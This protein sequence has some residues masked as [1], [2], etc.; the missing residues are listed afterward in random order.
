LRLVQTAAGKP[1]NPS[2]LGRPPRWR[3]SAR[4]QASMSPVDTPG[5]MR[6]VTAA[7]VVAAVRPA[8]RIASISEVPKRSI[9]TGRVCP[10]GRRTIQ[11]LF[12]LADRRDLGWGD[13][14]A[15]L[16]LNGEFGAARVLRRGGRGGERR[17]RS[18]APARLAAAAQSADSLPRGGARRA[19]V[20]AYATRGAAVAARG[21]AASPGSSHSG[22]HRLRRGGRP[23][24]GERTGAFARP[25]SSRAAAGRSFEAMTPAP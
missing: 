12:D 18:H 19:A 1:W 13:R 8:R 5:R 10:P 14:A 3:V 22:R 25:S 11:Y 7:S 6:A 24:R 23:S 9:A 4:T 16:H 20:R 15:V 21:H 17:T 2:W